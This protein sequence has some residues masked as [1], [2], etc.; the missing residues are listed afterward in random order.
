MT[1]ATLNSKKLMA[2]LYF[3]RL[4]RFKRK[5]ALGSNFEVV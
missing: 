5:I 1:M 3:R 4:S 2:T